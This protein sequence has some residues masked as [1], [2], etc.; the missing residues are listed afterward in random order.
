[1]RYAG[2]CASTLS[3]IIAKHNPV[4]RKIL[5]NDAFSKQTKK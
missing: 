3:F 5:K 4:F 2:V 1:M